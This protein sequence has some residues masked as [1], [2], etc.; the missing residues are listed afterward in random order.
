MGKTSRVTKSTFED[1]FSEY[2][3]RWG[4]NPSDTRITLWALDHMGLRR[5]EIA[6]F[7]RYVIENPY[8]NWT[9]ETIRSL[10]ICWN[11][12][13]DTRKA[14]LATRSLVAANI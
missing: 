8:D 14:E 6:S 7:Q 3:A 9:P 4:D 5:G 10:F 2:K 13:S 11:Q 1:S 12:L